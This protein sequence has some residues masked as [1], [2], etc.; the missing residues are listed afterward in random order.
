MRSEVCQGLSAA[1]VVF[2]ESSEAGGPARRIVRRPMVWAATRSRAWPAGSLMTSRVMPRSAAAAAGFSAYRP[3]RRRSRSSRSLRSPPER[4]WRSGRLRRD[5]PRS[6]G[7]DVQSQKM[8]KRVDGQVELRCPSCVRPGVI[9]GASA[10]S[11]G[12]RREVRLSMMTAVGCAPRP[13]A[14][15]RMTRKSS[16]ESLEASGFQPIGCRLL[17]RRSPHR[18]QV[19]SASSAMRGCRSSAI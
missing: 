16:A 4:P 5:H 6:A 11:Q 17:V 10:R 1:F 12:S 3:D 19:S 13:A 9:S 15:R 2:D 18:R 8:A 7:V 14:R